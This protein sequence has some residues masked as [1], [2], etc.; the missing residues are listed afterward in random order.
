M[1]NKYV[2]HLDPIITWRGLKVLLANYFNIF[3]HIKKALPKILYGTGTSILRTMMLKYFNNSLYFKSLYAFF[4][5]IRIL[6]K[7]K[8]A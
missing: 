1:Q 5:K 8:S 7:K 6:Q 3:Y 2:V 4:S